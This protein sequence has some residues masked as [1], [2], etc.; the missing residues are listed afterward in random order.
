MTPYR[1]SLQKIFK[2]STFF[3]FFCIFRISMTSWLEKWSYF[4]N[5]IN[6]QFWPF[7]HFIDLQLLRP[8]EA[9]SLSIKFHVSLLS[10][11]VE[12]K[13]DCNEVI[14]PYFQSTPNYVQCALLYN[15]KEC[16][17]TF[18]IQLWTQKLIFFVKRKKDYV[19]QYIS[20]EEA[21]Y[22]HFH[23]IFRCIC[24]GRL[25]HVRDSIM[26]D[27]FFSTSQL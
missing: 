27:V 21:I 3:K 23:C 15:V 19:L 14:W 12:V 5:L 24:R 13:Y 25:S 2:K 22:I 1:F 10:H 18:T 20:F 8:T 9:L 26:T 16:I 17:F 7:W 11:V 4:W 6:F